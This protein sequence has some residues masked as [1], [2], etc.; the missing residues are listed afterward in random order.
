MFTGAN[1]TIRIKDLDIKVILDLF[2]VKISTEEQLVWEATMDDYDLTGIVQIKK[3]DILKYTTLHFSVTNPQGFSYH[4][5]TSCRPNRK[6][7][8]PTNIIFIRFYNGYIPRFG[9][10]AFDSYDYMGRFYPDNPTILLSRKESK[11]TSDSDTFKVA[12]WAIK[13]I[14]E[15]APIL[16]GYS[17]TKKE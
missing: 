9:R 12:Q 2:P 5:L 3:E 6:S 16:A 7:T 1:P 13:V 15:G 14:W 8:P 17:I 11:C 4:Y 10:D